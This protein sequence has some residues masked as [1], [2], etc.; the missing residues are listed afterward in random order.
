M[1]KRK[2]VERMKLSEPTPDELRE[3]ARELVAQLD[4]NPEI[5]ETIALRM[6][7]NVRMVLI[8]AR[9]Y[10]ARQPL[11]RLF[12]ILSKWKDGRAIW[13]A[14]GF[15]GEQELE[16]NVEELAEPSEPSRAADV[17]HPSRGAGVT[18][19]RTRRADPE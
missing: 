12:N 1:T 9:W 7:F 10:R 4:T 8:G 17:T 5:K 18:P 15:K 14:L 16:E 6:A 2:R 3:S 11:P 19:H 13:F